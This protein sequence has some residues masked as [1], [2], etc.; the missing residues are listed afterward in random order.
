MFD[1]SRISSSK[2]FT[3][4]EHSQAGRDHGCYGEYGKQR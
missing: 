2:D 1:L 4:L 3:A